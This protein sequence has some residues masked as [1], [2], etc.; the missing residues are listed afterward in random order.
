L[1]RGSVR[2][3]DA[4]RCAELGDDDDTLCGASTG[5]DACVGDSGGPLVEEASEGPDR[6]IGVVSV[7]SG[8][9]VS[10][11]VVRYTPVDP[12]AAWIAETIQQVDDPLE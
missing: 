3:V 7:G 2:L 8:C 5:I 12:Y 4:S 9:A 1:S 11:P 6:L 10:N